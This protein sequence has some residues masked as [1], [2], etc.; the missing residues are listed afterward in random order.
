MSPR[1]Y[2]DGNDVSLTIISCNSVIA[3][4]MTQKAIMDLISSGSQIVLFVTGKNL[5]HMIKIALM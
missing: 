1:D 5:A 4:R 2:E 3:T